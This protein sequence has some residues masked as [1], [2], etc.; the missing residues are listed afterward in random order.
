MKTSQ[1]E[2][3]DPWLDTVR[4]LA[5]TL[6]LLSH[7]RIFLL[8]IWD[9]FD[10]LKFG[11]FLGVELFF[12]LS[13]YLIGGLIIDATSTQKAPFQWIKNFWINRWL[14]TIPNYLFFLIINITL[15]STGIRPTEA[16][17]LIKYLTFT[18]NISSHH[19]S[20]FPEA[21]SLATEEIFYIITPI[22]IASIMLAGCSNKKSI[23]VV[24]ILIIFS[25]IIA[26]HLVVEIT[27]PTWDEGIRKITSLRLDA[28]MIGVL[29]SLWSKSIYS[30][31]L[32]RNF[33]IFLCLLLVPIIYLT[34]QPNVELDRSWFARVLLFSLTSLSCAG[35]IVLGKYF[36]TFKFLILSKIALWSYSIYLVN[37]PILNFIKYSLPQVDIGLGTYFIYWILFFASSIF[38]SKLIF[39]NF[40]LY[41]I[42]IRNKIHNN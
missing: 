1:G 24:S 2:Q 3:R 18:Q 34:T 22:L 30:K 19:P 38:L 20:F 9:G 16:P 26:R 35:L 4:A 7:G 5:I 39:N 37:L 12:V 32:T 13:G 11:G 17:D 28:L 21:W 41:F 42:N 40:E 8:P 6:V 29:F 33:S 10:F 23:I 36:K 14:R 31:F 27:N 15:L 25:S